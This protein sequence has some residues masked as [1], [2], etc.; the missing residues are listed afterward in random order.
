M[1][2]DTPTLA[3]GPT[4][5]E[6]QRYVSGQQG[7][8]RIQPCSWI[9]QIWSFV[10]YITNKAAGKPTNMKTAYKKEAGNLF[11]LTITTTE[12]G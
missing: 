6:D 9:L 7:D 3:G 12:A 10:C 1:L 11:C 5:V 8:G 2:V 4:L